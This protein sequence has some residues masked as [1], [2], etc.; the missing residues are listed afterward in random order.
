[1][2]S[3]FLVMSMNKSLVNYKHTQLQMKT[4]PVNDE[5]QNLMTIESNHNDKPNNCVINHQVCK[6]GLRQGP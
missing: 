2:Q 5:M 3:H 6:L 4:G 1:M